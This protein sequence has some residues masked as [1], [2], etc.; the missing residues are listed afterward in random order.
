MDI[1]EV[2]VMVKEWKW[3]HEASLVTKNFSK[4]SSFIKD[5]NIL[6]VRNEGAIDE[7]N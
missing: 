7:T 5:T 3:E 1:D 2:K 4:T 6:Q